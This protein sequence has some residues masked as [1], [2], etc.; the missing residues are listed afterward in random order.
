MR[1]DRDFV[2]AAPQ[3]SV[4]PLDPPRARPLPP[5]RPQH[6]GR[7]SLKGFLQAQPAS[8]ALSVSHSIFGCLRRLSLCVF[9]LHDYLIIFVLL[10]SFPATNVWTY[11]PQRMLSVLF[12]AG[13]LVLKKGE[14]M[15]SK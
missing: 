7:P 8:Q 12:T 14:Y 10:I 13:S 9:P 1:C 4:L 11:D 6:Q 2:P 3:P 15:N 5:F